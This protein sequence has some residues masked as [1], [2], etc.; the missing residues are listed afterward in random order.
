MT[1]V[2]GPT[3]LDAFS[4]VPQLVLFGSR[5]AC[6][7]RLEKSTGTRSGKGQDFDLRVGSGTRLAPY[8]LLAHRYAFRLVPGS[9]PLI[10]PS[11]APLMA[12]I[13]TNVPYCLPNPTPIACPA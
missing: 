4:G 8:H 6:A 5:E 2:F 11:T 3:D 13:S 10:V 7:N 9:K 1:D 12:T